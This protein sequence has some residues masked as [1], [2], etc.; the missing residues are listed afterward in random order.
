MPPPVEWEL[1]LATSHPVARQANTFETMAVI[2]CVLERSNVSGVEG[3]G[4]WKEEA[5][6]KVRV[7]VRTKC[8]PE[9]PCSPHPRTLSGSASSSPGPHL[10]SVPPANLL[11]H[12]L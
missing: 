10:L 4:R 9:L 7:H 3:E 12:K 6:A 11:L 1:L 5:E 8:I 2:I